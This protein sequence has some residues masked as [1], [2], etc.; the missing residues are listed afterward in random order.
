MARIS[1]NS[2][3]VWGRSV[4]SID[5]SITRAG[6]PLA[7]CDA[8][9]DSAGFADRRQEVLAPRRRASA[10]RSPAG[11]RCRARQRTDK[12]LVA[13]RQTAPTASAPASAPIQSA[14]SSVK[15]S[16]A[17]RKASTVF[18]LTW[19]AS[20]KYGP[21]QRLACTAP[22]GFGPNVRRTTADDGVFAVRLVPDRR[23][24]NPLRGWR[25]SGHRVAASPDGQNGRRRRWSTWAIRS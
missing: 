21:V 4:S 15:K 7:C 25:E 11:G 5:T 6:P 24:I 1:S 18:R 19:S 22:I 23:N 17:A 20:T 9:I 13:E 3:G 10:G 14:T 16:L 12:T 2:I 8:A